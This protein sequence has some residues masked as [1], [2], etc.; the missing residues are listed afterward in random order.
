[1][2][3]LKTNIS[4]RRLAL[5]ARQREVVFHIHDLATIWGISNAHSLRVML[6]RYIDSGI[7]YRVYR[8]CYSL[9]PPEEID[10]VFLGA[11]LLH[12][13]CYLSMESILFLEGYRSQPSTY[14][15]FISGES[16]KFHILDHHFLSRQL[17]AQ[18]LYNPLGIVL[19]DSVYRASSERA[20]ADMLCGNWSSRPSRL[21][22]A[23]QVVAAQA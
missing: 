1:M 15:T 3:I 13:Y 5:L 20:I 17:S 4:A 23:W 7:L 9:I 14:V 19:K 8:G 6:K 11:K 10:A 16:K 21:W 18:Y 22:V 12:Q 2:S